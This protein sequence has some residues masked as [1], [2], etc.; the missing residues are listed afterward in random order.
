MFGLENQ[1]PTCYNLSMN[2]FT[3][4]GIV[5]LSV[6][7]MAFLQLTPGVFALFGHYATGKFGKKKASYFSTFFII[8]TETVAAA[9]F[10]AAA[11]FS[12]LLFMYSFQPETGLTGWLL[13]GIMV[14]LALASFLYYFRRGNGTQLF[15]PRKCAETLERYAATANSRSDAF[16]L[17]AMSGILELPFSLP[18]YLIC[19]LSVMELTAVEPVAVLLGLIFILA[20]LLPLVTLRIKRRAGYNLAEIQRVRAHDK[21]FIRLILCFAYVT[22]AVLLIYVG[23]M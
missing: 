8:G 3:S 6:L 19:A 7:I 20:P 16:I 9:L 18:V 5:I 17:G 11:L 10:I 22:I 14:A 23:I 1:P 21:N 15:I 4:L 2:I 12:N 13:T